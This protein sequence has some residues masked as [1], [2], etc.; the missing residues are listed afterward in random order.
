MYKYKSQTVIRAQVIPNGASLFIQSP[1]LY[2]IWTKGF[3]LEAY[4]NDENGIIF[5]HRYTYSEL[6]DAARDQALKSGVIKDSYIESGHFYSDI[7]TSICKIPGLSNH[8]F[9]DYWLHQK[10]LQR[11]N[12]GPLIKT[13]NANGETLDKGI[14]YVYEGLYSYQ[15]LEEIVFIYEQAVKSLIGRFL[16]NKPIKIKTEVLDN[17]NKKWH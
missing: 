11:Y 17:K 7:F 10:E 1:E 4:D 3:Y 8:N 9:D 6:I 12:S 5:S 16:A 2:T 13:K 15:I 14:K